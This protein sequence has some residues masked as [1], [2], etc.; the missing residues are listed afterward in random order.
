MTDLLR[1][2]DILTTGTAVANFKG[3]RDVRAEHLL[4][5]I[6]ILL[7]EQTLDDLG[8]PVSPMLSRATGAGSGATGGVRS[9][10][11]HWFARQ[12]GDVTRELAAESLAELRAELE[13]LAAEE[14]AT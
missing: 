10:A 13:R 6:A 3:E 7:G 11:Q 5:A 9:L 2:T 14:A 8:R 4:S 1:L 12:D